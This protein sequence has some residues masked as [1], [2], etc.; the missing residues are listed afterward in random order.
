MSS[1][2]LGIKYDILTKLTLMSKHKNKANQ[3]RELVERT[4]AWQSQGIFDDMKN[5]FLELPGFAVP[6]E[7]L[8]LPNHYA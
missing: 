6:S 4:S 1:D 5:C 3:K 2:T 8:S 7:I